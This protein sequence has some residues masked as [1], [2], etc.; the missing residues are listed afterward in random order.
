MFYIIKVLFNTIK[1]NYFREMRLDL[2]GEKVEPLSRGWRH[3]SLF[4]SSV[5]NV[6]N[7]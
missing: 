7:V 1:N 3:S 2:K 5:H 4:F 6:H